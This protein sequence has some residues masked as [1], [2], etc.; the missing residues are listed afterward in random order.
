VTGRSR[1]HRMRFS[2]AFTT[3]CAII[4]L[5]NAWTLESYTGKSFKGTVARYEIGYDCVTTSGQLRHNTL[6]IRSANRW[7]CVA[8]LDDHCK[9][10][11]NDIDSEGWGNIG[12][13]QIS[14][15]WCQY[16]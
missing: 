12:E 16:I 8:Y 1:T 15:V 7:R 2:V 3:V 9:K 5:T 14:S 13:V 4:P 11:W 10:L 6:S